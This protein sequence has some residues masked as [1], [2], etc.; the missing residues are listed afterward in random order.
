MVSIFGEMV[1]KDSR[2]TFFENDQKERV[3]TGRTILLIPQV[4]GLETKEVLPIPLSMNVSIGYR[5][6]PTMNIRA[7]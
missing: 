4:R 3:V 2:V 7:Y 6:V 1:F 5:I